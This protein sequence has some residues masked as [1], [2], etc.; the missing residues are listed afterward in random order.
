M[1]SDNI[2]YWIKKPVKAMLI[3]N[4]GKEL[5]KETFMGRELNAFVGRKMITTLLDTNKNVVKTEKLACVTKIVLSLDELDNTDNLE[6]G[7]LSNVQLRYHLTGS[8]EFTHLEP[9]TPQYK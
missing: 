8:E 5:Q 6:D 1:F 7:N 9:L 2:Q 3:M 4:E